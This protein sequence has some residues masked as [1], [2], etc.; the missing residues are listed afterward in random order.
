MA[1]GVQSSESELQPDDI[2]RILKQKNVIKYFICIKYLIK[3]EMSA[4]RKGRE[5]PD[6]PS[7]VSLQIA[8]GYFIFQF[9]KTQDTTF[10]KATHFKII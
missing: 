3:W 1:P 5:C 2:N 9:Y 10:K 7:S 4:Y 6:Y 8:N